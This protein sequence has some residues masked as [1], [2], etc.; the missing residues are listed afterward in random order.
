MKAWHLFLFLYV[1]Q[2]LVAA[3]IP[4]YISNAHYTAYYV[5]NDALS[6]FTDPTVVTSENQ[7]LAANQYF[8]IESK[9]KWDILLSG[10]MP[11]G[12][13]IKSLFPNVIPEAIVLLLDSIWGIIFG[14]SMLEFMRGMKI[15][16][17]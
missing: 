4:Q 7:Y 9:S 2:A 16:G 6:N 17:D 1:F 8:G 13:Y 3:I 12:E 15:F 10:L 5:P 14:L 11:L